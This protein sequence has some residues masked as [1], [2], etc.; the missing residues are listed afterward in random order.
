MKNN[1]L[2]NVCKPATMKLPLLYSVLGLLIILYLTEASISAQEINKEVYVIRPYEPTLSDAEKF[3]FMPIT[4]DVNPVPPGF[5]YSINPVK[6]DNT[7][8]PEPIKAAKT[9]AT[10]VPKIYN[11][12]LKVGL[13]N[14][15]TPLVEF[16]ISNLHSKD[17]S[18]GA[19]L[20]HKSSH[21][22]IVLANEDKV[23]AYYAF[24]NI[25]IYGSKFFNKAAL[26]GKLR[27]NNQALRY[28]GYNTEVFDDPALVN[29]SSDS[30]KQA[31]NIIGAD[32]GIRSYGNDS[33]MINY[34]FNAAFDYLFDRYGNNETGLIINTGAKKS[35]NGLV[36]GVDITLDYSKPVTS[37]DS[38]ANTVFKFHPYISKSSRDWKFNLGFEAV[39]DMADISHFYVYPRANLDIIIVDDVL[40]P[41]IGLTGYLEKNNYR[42]V[43]SEN[44]YV[45]PGTTIKNSSTNLQAYGGIKG[46]ISS[47]IRFRADVTYKVIKNEHF[48]VTDTVNWQNMFVAVYDD[49]DLIVYH[50]QIVV[51]PV[52]KIELLI[53]GKY[54]KYNVYDQKKP[55]HKPDF[56]IDVNLDYNITSKLFVQ[57]GISITGN[58]WA[59][60]Y[61]E[62]D[63]PVKF[64][65]VAD[66]NLKIK[67]NY[68]NV[69]GIF[70]DFHNMADRS[71]MIWNQYPS[72]RFNFLIGL[73]YKL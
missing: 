49:I 60:N 40:V 39:S 27:Y 20:Y 54:N 65:P 16:N 73:T 43:L 23:P 51:Q 36:G 47:V 7:F 53:D 59:W 68:S 70:A 10:S 8:T 14:Y 22:K 55:W 38:V 46:S 19:Y 52:E 56:T 17:I 57:S 72:Q 63:L 11:S 12:M 26:T 2:Y 13:G 45:K 48:F 61:T 32:A 33:S 41:F 1:T 3:N 62:P 69:L 29:I 18:Y 30:I 34:Y 24:N 28:Y 9:V 25:N 37:V 44:L 6:L 50:G 71:Y 67:Y 21:G 64:K 42:S 5:K 35:F 15:S 31:I 58:R 66:I 4:E